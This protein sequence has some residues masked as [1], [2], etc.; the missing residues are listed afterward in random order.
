VAG[1]EV[2]G[3]SGG[4]AAVLGSPIEHSISPQLH[5]AAYAELGLTG[6]TYE[7]IELDDA[8][9]PAW[10]AG[11][12]P[13]QWLGLSLTMPLKEVALPLM[14]RLSPS[15]VA[16][17]AVNTVTWAHDEQ[18]TPVGDNTDVRGIVEAFHSAG[19]TQVGTACVLGAGATARSAVSALAQLGTEHVTVLARS[20]ERAATAI[21]LASSLG[22]NAAYAPLRRID[23]LGGADAIISALPF[24][25]ADE[26]AA[27]VRDG[28]VGGDPFAGI[29]G[30]LLDVVYRDWPT[31]LASAWAD[32]GGQSVS[33]FE[34][35]LHQAAA[36]VL[37]MTGH[38]A[39]L[40]AMRAAGTAALQTSG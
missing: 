15:A 34:M 20:P 39:P 2:T 7:R 35:L 40:E 19:L 14:G 27:A 31:P 24:G 36:Q 8:A 3:Q 32:S 13:S 33:G 11:L 5:Q 9:F 17:G 26:L 28:G 10:F 25:V 30:V 16:T 29:A 6:A 18:R 23:L 4:R 1:L 12:D 22:L 21:G 37:L 38:E